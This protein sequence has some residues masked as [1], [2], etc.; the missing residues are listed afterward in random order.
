MTEPDLPDFG[1]GE[2]SEED[3]NF[4]KGSDD[5]APK[6]AAAESSKGKKVTWDDQKDGSEDEKEAGQQ[7]SSSKKKRSR[8]RTKKRTRE[9]TKAGSSRNGRTTAGAGKVMVGGRAKEEDG[10]GV[11]R[12]RR[13]LPSGCNLWG[14]S[15]AGSPSDCSL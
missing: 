15:P 3:L 13:V 14:G 1:T 7:S 6:K 10:I 9:R 5:P 12:S 4:K 8:K 11:G 2:S